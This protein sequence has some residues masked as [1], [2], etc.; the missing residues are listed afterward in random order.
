MVFFMVY[1]KVLES[2]GV[3]YKI[4]IS[5]EIALFADRLHN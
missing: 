1:E 2:R 4:L 3:S 5:S